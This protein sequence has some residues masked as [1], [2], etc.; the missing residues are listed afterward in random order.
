M[1]FLNTHWKMTPHKARAEPMTMDERTLGILMFLMMYAVLAEIE[2]GRRIDAMMSDTV[3]LTDPT[4]IPAMVRRTIMRISINAIRCGLL[5]IC[6]PVSGKSEQSG[7]EKS[8]YFLNGIDVPD[9]LTLRG[10]AV[11]YIDFSLLAGRKLAVRLKACEC[12]NLRLRVSS[13]VS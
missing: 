7:I 13:L 2:L 9:T 4:A 6:T 11:D 10:I 12:G 5:L 8:C 3:I 1:G